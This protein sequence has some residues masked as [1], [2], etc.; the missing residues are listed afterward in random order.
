MSLLIDDRAG[1]KELAAP[2]EK[3]GLDVTLTRLEFGDV[4]FEGRG[5][6]G[7]TVDVGIEFKRLGEMVTSIRDGRFAGHQLPGLAMYDHRW[8]L[9]EGYWKH[10]ATTGKIVTYQGRG[11]GWRP[12]HGGMSA[13]E[14]EKHLLTFELCGGVHVRQTNARA[15]SL[16]VL[17]DMYRWWT[18]SALDDHTSHVAV[19]QPAT[20]APLSDYRA[21]VYRWPGVGIKIS[22]AVEEKWG[23]SILDAAKAGPEEWSELTTV[24]GSGKA[25]RFGHEAAQRVVRFLRGK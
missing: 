16:R 17:A 21:A 9:I 2:L 8:L 22:A 6:K 12:L 1:S 13:S 7:S 24:D 3:L 20:M 14:Y 10:D 4:A 11:R 19:H 15:D 18:D 23:P 5:V 25:R